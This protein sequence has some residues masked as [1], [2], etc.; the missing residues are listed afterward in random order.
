MKLVIA[1]GPTFLLYVGNMH[2]PIIQCRKWS[3]L[4]HKIRNFDFAIH[5]EVRDVAMEGVVLRFFREMSS[6]CFSGQ[7]V[8]SNVAFTEETFLELFQKRLRPEI[9]HFNKISGISEQQLRHV[10]DQLKSK[11]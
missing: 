7:I 2:T 11:I 3:Q 4:K 1:S 9:L 5:T 10:S 8:F 6:N